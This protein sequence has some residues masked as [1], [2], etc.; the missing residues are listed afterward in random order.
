MG[1]RASARSHASDIAN[2]KPK[3]NTSRLQCR[4]QYRTSKMIR[5]RA[6]RDTSNYVRN[7]GA[8]ILKLVY[9]APYPKQET[10]PRHCNYCICICVL[11]FLLAVL[12]CSPLIVSKHFRTH[13]ERPKQRKMLP[14][15]TFYSRT[16]ENRVQASPCCVPVVQ[17]FS[18]FFGHTLHAFRTSTTRAGSV[19]NPSSP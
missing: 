3:T 17:L 9:N 2:Q 4:L 7:P 16:G 14:P 18:L 5:N 15:S 6:T 8:A 1:W 19:V 12:L 10:K 13:G 11:C